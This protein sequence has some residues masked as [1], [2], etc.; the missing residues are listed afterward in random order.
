MA[1]IKIKKNPSRRGYQAGGP[2]ITISK[3]HTIGLNTAAWELIGKPAQ[4]EIAWDPDTSR[5]MLTASSPHEDTFPLSGKS[6][7]KF[8]AR[9]LLRDLG[10]DPRGETR[11]FPV[12]RENRLSLIADLSD[13]PA[14]STGTVTPIRRTA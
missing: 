7:A 8:G 10:V 1:F 4:V 2:Q 6:G 5:V 9:Q 13:M 12:T 3:Q 11:R 14:A